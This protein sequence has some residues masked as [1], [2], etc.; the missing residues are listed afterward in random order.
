MQQ[1]YVY[2]QL[3][4]SWKGITKEEADE[5]IKEGHVYG[6]TLEVDRGDAE[7]LQIT[8]LKDSFTLFGATEAMMQELADEYFAYV[9]SITG[10]EARPA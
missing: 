8:L 6:C 3:I 4:G 10:M 5:K 2:K 9:E 7:P 1:I